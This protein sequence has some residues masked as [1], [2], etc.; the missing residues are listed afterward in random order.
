MQART[1]QRNLVRYFNLKNPTT[2]NIPSL[3][4]KSSSI[5]NLNGSTDL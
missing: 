5:L 1:E 4:K 2:E 3:G